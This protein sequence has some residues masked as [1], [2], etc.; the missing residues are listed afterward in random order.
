MTLEKL[1]EK[2]FYQ[3]PY[4]K[5]KLARYYESIL[6][7]LNGEVFLLFSPYISVHRTLL[8]NTIAQ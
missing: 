7:H 8:V 1:D 6:F 5:L 4:S 3:G 2:V